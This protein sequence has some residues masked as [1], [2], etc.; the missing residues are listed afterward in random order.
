MGVGHQSFWKSNNEWINIPQKLTGVPGYVRTMEQILTSSTAHL[1]RYHWLNRLSDGPNWQYGYEGRNNQLKNS[2]LENTQ[3]CYRLYLGLGDTWCE[4]VQ[5]SLHPGPPLYKIY[6]GKLQ[7][8]HTTVGI[9]LGNVVFAIV[10]FHEW[11][12]LNSSCQCIDLWSIQF[13]HNW[14]WG[15]GIKGGQS[16]ICVGQIC[17]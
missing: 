11:Y 9:L 2:Q 12:S 5:G 7:G 3:A 13:P 10:G 4:V 14:C 17:W 15:V 6:W 16:D 1:W 8:D